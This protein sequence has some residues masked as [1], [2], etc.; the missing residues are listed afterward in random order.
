MWKQGHEL[1]GS[2]NEVNASFLFFFF[3][4]LTLVI[5]LLSILLSESNLENN[6]I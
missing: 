6:N 1:C 3:P 5:I 2:L 4:Y